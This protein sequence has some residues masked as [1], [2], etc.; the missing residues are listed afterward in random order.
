MYVQ[1]I[2]RSLFLSNCRCFGRHVKPAPSRVEIKDWMKRDIDVYS[3][4]SSKLFR[5][6]FGALCFAGA[7]A[8]FHLY[9]YKF[10]R[11]GPSLVVPV[12]ELVGVGAALWALRMFSKYNVS[13]MKLLKGG[14]QLEVTPQKLFGEPR[15]RVIRLSEIIIAPVDDK[16]NAFR[17]RTREDASWYAWYSVDKKGTIQNDEALAYILKL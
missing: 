11:I 8:I 6:A 1:W 7:F 12:V 3:H 5:V 15:L 9:D 2:K 10:N 14:L 16:Q 4:E 13:K 17:F